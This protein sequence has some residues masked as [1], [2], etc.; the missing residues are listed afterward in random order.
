MASH[1]LNEKIAVPELNKRSPNDVDAY[2]G[3]RIRFRRLTLNLTQV[4]LANLLDISFQQVQ[5]YEKGS[6]RVGASRLQEI[7]D[8]LRVPITFFFD[9][10]PRKTVDTESELPCES[11]G[12][13]MMDFLFSTEGTKLV[14]AF[15]DIP[16]EKTR[17]SIVNLII[18]LANADKEH[19]ANQS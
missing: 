8:V 5:K 15:T 3:S 6:N 11:G 4:Q 13:Q 7:A 18:E 12:G 10:V 16:C 9:G 2:I 14:R 17:Q 1:S 19:A